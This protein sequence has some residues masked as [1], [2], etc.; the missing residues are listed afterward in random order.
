MLPFLS[1]NLI[2]NDIYKNSEREMI[3]LL[4]SYELTF[5]F[6]LKSCSVERKLKFRKVCRNSSNFGGFLVLT[7]RIFTY[8]NSECLILTGNFLLV[9]TTKKYFFICAAARRSVVF[10]RL[11]VCLYVGPS[12]FEPGIYLSQ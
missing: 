7:L 3:N 8:L 1:S 10:V 4:N 6:I 5:F 2:K 11:S 9:Q 12:V